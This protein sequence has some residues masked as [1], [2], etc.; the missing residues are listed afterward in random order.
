MDSNSEAENISVGT[1]NPDYPKFTTHTN[2]IYSYYKDFAMRWYL[3]GEPVLTGHGLR[4]GTQNRDK[5]HPEWF[6]LINGKRTADATWWQ[7]CY[8]NQEFAKEIGR[9]LL[10]T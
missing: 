2:N 5:N 6:S 8:S 9:K 1:L 7:Y 10:N 4:A 3:G